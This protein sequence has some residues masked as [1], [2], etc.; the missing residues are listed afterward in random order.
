MSEVD[1]DW[2][3]D[4]SGREVDENSGSDEENDN[5]ESMVEPEVDISAS[6][7]ML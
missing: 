2:S 3:S 7:F 6:Q 4:F 5:S 1:T